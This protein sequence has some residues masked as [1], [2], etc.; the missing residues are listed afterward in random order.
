VVGPRKLYIYVVW[1][2]YCIFGGSS[3]SCCIFGG[4][5]VF[6]VGPKFFVVCFV[7]SPR[8]VQLGALAEAIA[9]VVSL[10]TVLVAAAD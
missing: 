2:V 1:W 7:G 5:N 8:L 3:N 6:L 10:G 9:S 4:S